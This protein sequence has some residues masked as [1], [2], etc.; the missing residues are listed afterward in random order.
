MVLRFFDGK[1]QIIRFSSDPRSCDFSRVYYSM[2]QWGNDVC[3][4][5]LCLH[6][7]R[8]GCSPEGLAFRDG[9]HGGWGG[10]GPAFQ[11]E[12]KYI[13]AEG[14]GWVGAGHRGNLAEGRRT[15]EYPRRAG[16][17]NSCW[18]PRLQEGFGICGILWSVWHRSLWWCHLRCLQKRLWHQERQSVGRSVYYSI[19]QLCD[20]EEATQPFWASVTFSPVTWGLL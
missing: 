19:P 18:C 4:Q 9:R 3:S 20:P 14:W 1:P 11:E 8:W 10:S 15:Q 17:R 5:Q 7:G 13:M 12:E 16:G 2:W 6:P